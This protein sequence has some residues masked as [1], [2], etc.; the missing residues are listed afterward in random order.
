VF[1]DGNTTVESGA[2]ID[3]SSAQRDAGF[4]ELSAKNAV[5]LG[6]IK[7]DLSA[8]NGKAGTLLIDPT[9][10]VIDGG[11]NSTTS[12]TIVS[13]GGNVILT[14]SNS[15]TITST[16]AIDTR[17]FDRNAN[18][19][20]LSL[21]N[22]ST[23]NSGSVSL[24]AP[25]LTIA[26]KILTNVINAGGTT[27]SA[28]DVS[29]TATATQTVANSS[30]TADTKIT[31]SGEI[32]A[33]VVNPNGASRAGDI[34]LLATS[35]STNFSGEV[36]ANSEITIS[37][38]LT[39][40][41]ITTRARSIATS[42]FLDGVQGTMALVGT[43]AAANFLGLNGGY[44]AGTTSAKVTIGTNASLTA[45]RD[46]TL[47][48][49]ATET[50]SN[51][52]MALLSLSPVGAAVVV[53]SINATVETKVNTQ[54]TIHAG[55]NLAINAKNEA[56]LAVSALAVST[57]AIAEATVAYSKV[58]VNTS[59]DVAAGAGI[60]AGNVSVLGSNTNSFSTAAT[61]VAFGAGSVGGAVAYSDVSTQV[62]ANFGAGLGSSGAPIAGNLSVEALSDTQRMSTG[63]STQVGNN[64]IANGVLGELPVAF[65]STVTTPLFGS[66]LGVKGGAALALTSS[67]QAAQASI[68][69]GSGTAP[70]IYAA[71][72]SVISRTIDS[73]IR[74]N[75]SAD[76][77]AS[78]TSQNAPSIVVSTGVAYGT[79]RHE[80]T[81]FIGHGVSITG[82]NIGVS[83]TTDLP[84]ENTWVQTWRTGSVGDIL[85]HLNGNAGVVG[86]ILTS[87]ANTTAAG[88]S[89][90]SAAGSVSLFGVTNETT[91]WVATDARLTQSNPTQA[92]ACSHST[93][94][95]Q[96][97]NG[98]FLD[99]NAPVSITATT[100]TRS[101][102]VA[103]NFGIFSLTGTGS[104]GSGVGGSLNL[105]FYN[106]T[107]IAGIARGATVSSDTQVAVSAWTNDIFFA[108]APTS[109]VAAGSLSLNGVASYAGI[110]NT[111]HASIDN[112][113]SVSAPT[114]SVKATENLQLMSLS[115]AVTSGGTAGVGLSTAALDVKSDTKAYIGANETDRPAVA[116]QSSSS[117]VGSH[118][119]A[120]NLTVY[121]VTTGQA[122]VASIAAAESDPASEGKTFAGKITSSLSTATSFAD[123]N[124]FFVAIS[125][126]K[127]A[128][129]GAVQNKAGS[130]T[131]PSFSIDIAGSA[132][133]T[134]MALDTTATVNGATIDRFTQPSGQT[135]PPRVNVDIEAL[136]STFVNAGSGAAAL[137][138]Q[139]DPSTTAVAVGG[140]MAIGVFKNATTAALTSSSVSN[141]GDVA[142]RAL[143]SG[144]QT[145]VGLGM[146]VAAS[147]G[148]NSSAA[149][150]SASVGMVTDSVNASIANSSITGV[151][152]G[153]GRDVVAQAYQTT[154]IG[155][156]AGALYAGVKG[157]VGISLT[158]VS[159]GDPAGRHAADAHLSSTTVTNADTL[160]V[161][162]VDA[163]RISSGAATA[164][165]QA[166]TDGTGLTGAIIINAITPTISAAILDNQSN[167]IRLTGDLVVTASGTRNAT[168]EAKI[169][170]DSIGVD[171]AAAPGGSGTYDFS[172][173]RLVQG[174]ISGLR[175]GAAVVAVAGQVGIGGSNF[176]ASVVYNTI[177]QTYIAQI[178]TSDI[179]T[180]S[181]GDVFVTAND[182][183]KI[184]AVAVGLAIS[185]GQYAGTGSLVLNQV[186]DSVSAQIGGTGATTTNTIVNGRN[187]AVV[188]ANA[189]S[190]EAGAGIA[191]FAPQATALGIASV[192]NT[193]GNTIAAAIDGGSVA[194][195]NSVVLKGGSTVDIR[196]VA[197]G[198]VMAQNFGLAGSLATNLLSTNV[199]ARI[200][201][202]AEVM[203]ANN[204]GVLAANSDT[205]RVIAGAAVASTGSSG[206]GAAVVV[207]T[208]SGTTQA[209]VSDAGTKVDAKAADLNDDLLVN[210]GQ[211]VHAIDVGTASRPSDNPPD[212]I[213]MQQ[214]V[215]GL[216]IVASSHQAVVTNALSA[217]LAS[218]VAAGLTP[219]TNVTGG[220]TKAYVDGAAIDTRLT[221]GAN[222]P[223]IELLASSFSYA[224]NFAL[225]SALGGSN[226]GGAAAVGM[227]MDR[228]T[229]ADM[230]NATIGSVAVQ[231]DTTSN[232]GTSVITKT[233]VPVVGTVRVRAVAEQDASNIV[234]AGGGGGSA[235]LAASGAVTLYRADTGP[236]SPAAVSRRRASRSRPA[237]PTAC[238]RRPARAPWEAPPVSARRSMS[239][240]PTTT[241]S[242]MSAPRASPRW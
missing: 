152:G 238:S 58:R 220:T 42:S 74:N 132:S 191:T 135:T 19:G 57:S 118:F 14:A 205:I 10:M 20:V 48:S 112:L 110:N 56:N 53:G 123:P 207:N 176:G 182:S 102:D 193:V 154:D 43:V 98:D 68:D 241:R 121:A 161:S 71:D 117:S 96:Q 197:L 234:T 208:I 18:G 170:N 127:N 126:A 198:G 242:P 75:A 211:L 35:T 41:D 39:G 162:A 159:I 195:G 180:G 32:N 11:T 189:G 46:V 128:G 22:P 138:F 134:V 93:W 113:A 215:N 21:S 82:R 24:T 192:T 34:A 111:T 156:G 90:L 153:S 85:S 84:N 81:A 100:I 114:I 122:T 147:A 12:T 177:A 60:S 3:V 107:T 204:V 228:K 51:P 146:A 87:Y 78:N 99:W 86:N 165:G 201:S 150:L 109:G 196:A 4:V 175:N 27:W 181:S 52:A 171:G 104:D 223:Q 187:I 232:N 91:A 178:G 167:Q 70:S 194:A 15:I 119:N 17:L 47:E 137:N 190:I 55:R 206:L 139:A 79:Y 166:S 36:I 37:G 38:T 124:A 203:A 2:R 40:R 210:K 50:A 224:G 240:S 7:L 66:E 33:S 6:V 212:L 23:G 88:S 148:Q 92:G 229:Y 209:Y 219:V 183:S 230:T 163:A 239:R 63:A 216:A 221:A 143:A 67:N 106:N 141:A 142:V 186:N 225:G 89:N 116:A 214:I 69:G 9:D 231:T 235:G 227:R 144:E 149:S 174:G 213:E 151:S 188:A 95:T 157:G 233:Y 168:L 218:S 61:A 199:T 115:G 94:C 217:G 164:G 173:G 133:A 28:G 101:L 155:V 65:V 29:L 83:A 59:V 31:I 103:G 145:L 222:A 5:A 13:N 25:N 97:S 172:G 237:A 131:P 179:D 140:S 77:A 226:G 8:P 62:T 45:T 129:A 136:N 72:V 125:A 120:D 54:A 160:T 108:L 130:R 185:S 158:Y 1:A 169:A 76:V 105:V 236:T 184:M 80:S 49:Y 30:H 26:G 200:T 64:F 44:V 202:G 16:G 73:A